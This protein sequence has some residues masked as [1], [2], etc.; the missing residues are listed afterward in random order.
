MLNDILHHDLHFFIVAL[1]LHLLVLV[2]RCRRACRL[3][4]LVVLAVIAA[5]V[6]VVLVRTQHLDQVEVVARARVTVHQYEAIAEAHAQ[7]T[8]KEL[9]VRLAVEVLPYPLV[10]VEKLGAIRLQPLLPEAEP[11][12][13]HVVQ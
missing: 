12:L 4:I 8:V 10:L 5:I 3:T 13:P 11:D 2:F 7:Y 9:H 6:E 1:P